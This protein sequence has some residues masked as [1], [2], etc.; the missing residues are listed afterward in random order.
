MSDWNKL[1]LLRTLANEDTTLKVPP[2]P[3]IKGADCSCKSHTASF[4]ARILLTKFIEI[5]QYIFVVCV[6]V[7]LFC[8][9]LFFFWRLKVRK[10]CLAEACHPL[11][12]SYFRDVLGI[13]GLLLNNYVYTE[14]P[15]RGKS[16]NSFKYNVWQK[17]FPFR[18]ASIDKWSPC[19]TKFR[20]RILHPFSCSTLALL[21]TFRFED[22]NDYEYEIRFKVFS[23]IVKI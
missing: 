2:V 17:R 6:C 23:R 11:N 4:K 12:K 1:P 14:A 13:R 5:W 3:S 22:E 20:K 7:F 8:F 9:V 21:E 15:R 10:C 16:P 19:H 18:I